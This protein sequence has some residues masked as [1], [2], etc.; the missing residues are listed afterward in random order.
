MRVV[1]LID[2]SLALD[3]AERRAA[4][5]DSLLVAPLPAGLLQHLAVLVLTYLLAPLFDD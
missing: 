4:V 1:A 5:V 3:P 2:G